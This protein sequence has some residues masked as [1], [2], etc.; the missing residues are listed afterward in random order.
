M[1]V[2][3]NVTIRIAG[4]EILKGASASLPAGRRVGLVGRNGAGKS[5]LFKAILNELHPDLGEISKPARWR[6]GQVAQEVPSSD[7][8]LL[9]TVLAADKERIALLA[10]SETGARSAQAWRH[11]SPP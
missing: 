3:D 1:L 4:R 10:Q 9:D 8:S 7:V 11:P 5:T 2:I 6:V